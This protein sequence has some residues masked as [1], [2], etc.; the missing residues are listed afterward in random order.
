MI[1][2]LYLF[3]AL[4]FCSAQTL[5]GLQVKLLAL[6]SKADKKFKDY[7]VA[8]SLLGKRLFAAEEN[9]SKALETIEKQQEKV[10]KLIH[11]QLLCGCAND[12]NSENFSG[13]KHH[14]GV[15]LLLDLLLKDENFSKAPKTTKRTILETTKRPT[16]TKKTTTTTMTPVTIKTTTTTKRI[17]DLGGFDIAQEATTAAPDYDYDFTTA[18]GSEPDE[19]KCVE[20]ADINAFIMSTWKNTQENV[21]QFNGDVV[22]KLPTELPP[23]SILLIKFDPP[24]LE[25]ETWDQGFEML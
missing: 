9:L 6:Q 4:E 12:Y 13:K 2:I 3:I 8:F 19:A 20:K 5:K 11:A 7:E 22:A 18:S 14:V 15:N 24:L 1:L 21:F 10:D 25:I 16:T 23:F 17:Q